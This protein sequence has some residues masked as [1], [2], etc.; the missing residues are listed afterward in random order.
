LILYS[1][2]IKEIKEAMSTALTM[3]VD[4]QMAEVSRSFILNYPKLLK[5]YSNRSASEN[6]RLRNEYYK[7]MR[8]FTD[9]WYNH[10]SAGVWFNAPFMQQ[11][12]P[13]ETNQS[14]KPVKTIPEVGKRLAKDL[15]EIVNSEET[16]GIIIDAQYNDYVS[17]DSTYDSDYDQ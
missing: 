15:Y 10:P 1:Q 5:H 8:F 6:Y 16:E 17:E 3:D 2:F 14:K 11:E 12:E 9:Y 7:H 4:S 13:D